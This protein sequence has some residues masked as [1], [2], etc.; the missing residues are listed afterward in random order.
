MDTNRFTQV[1]QEQKKEF[2]SQQSVFFV[3]R[4]KQKDVNITSYL[5]QVIT[6]IRRCGKSTLAHM[7]LQEN[8]YA[9]VNFDDERLS[10]I[11]ASDLNNILEALYAIYGNFNN[12]L[13]DE[14]QNID[15][16]HLFVNR[17]L[18]S[19]MRIIITGSNSKLLSR[20]IA[21][22]L[23]GRYIPIELF[24]FSFKEYLLANEFQL[25]ELETTRNKGLIV[26]HFMNYIKTGGFPEVIKGEDK[27]KYVS[28]LFDAIVTRD[29]IYRYGIRHTRTFRE[30]ALYLTGSFSSEISFNRLKK[31]FYLGSVN[32]AKNYV[33]YLEEAWLFV[34]LPKFSFKKQESIR[35]K[36]LYLIDTSF[37]ELA[38]ESSTANTGKL[39]ENIVMIHLLRNKQKYDYEIFYYKHNV[40]VDFVIYR[41]QRIN[42]LIQVAFSL[43][44]EKT[45]TREIRALITATN[46]LKA[47]KLTII[48]MEQKDEL[49]V[50]GHIIHVIPVAEWML[51]F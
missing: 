7:I 4:E 28:N 5:A 3:K 51:S 50:N 8:D 21:S 15:G 23:T 6:G 38:G 11:N 33:E 18:R 34:S 24:P 12:L 31:I 36:K 1:I 29:I 37:A 42:E 16:W 17:L 26:N 10:G 22:H 14:I 40:E 19:K 35:N 41:A 48:T 45:R 20:E 32:T 30:I 43:E 39:L 13:L 25:K 46:Y 9:Y 47:K 2:S 27:K 44:D 49:Q